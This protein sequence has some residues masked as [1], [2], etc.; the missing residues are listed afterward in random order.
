MISNF[1]LIFKHN[2]ITSAK[3]P[4]ALA[5][6]RYIVWWQLLDHVLWRRRCFHW[7]SRLLACATGIH[8]LRSFTEGF[9]SEGSLL[10]LIKSN[11]YALLDPGMQSNSVWSLN[12]L[13]FWREKIIQGG[14]TK[15]IFDQ[16]W[17]RFKFFTNHEAQMPQSA[18]PQ[19][20]KTFRSFSYVSRIGRLHESC[21][22]MRCVHRLLHHIFPAKPKHRCWTIAP[23]PIQE[24]SST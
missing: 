9:P 11:H 23:V 21:W 22:C 19:I 7:R 8:G 14:R 6:A 1:N 4:T 3:Y 12:V 13:K 15:T 24:M 20:C 2:Q 18:N 16:S 10:I 5:F 17:H